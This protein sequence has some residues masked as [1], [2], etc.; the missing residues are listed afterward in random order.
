M[1]K[2]PG[3][4]RIAVFY[5]DNIFRKMICRFLEDDLNYPKESIIFGEDIDA[6]LTTLSDNPASILISEF[7]FLFGHQSFNRFINGDIS[8]RCIENDV[9]RVIIVPDANPWLIQ[10]IINMQFNVTLSL[11]D[12]SNELYKTIT[13]LQQ[14][15][16]GAPFVSAH[17][18]AHMRSAGKQRFPLSPGEREILH[19]MA[20]GLT[21]NEIAQTRQ[22][23]GSTIA[24]QKH[25]AM[26]KLG[27]TSNSELM[28]YLLMMENV[29]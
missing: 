6:L 10:H 13:H 18:K 16:P 8:R 23:T 27:V 20:Q 15:E 7:S 24:T 11:Y 29:R 26:K 12:N 14:S 21:L 25:N 22:R 9:R 17:L 4:T 3:H 19:M 5:R 1:E 2:P 28:K